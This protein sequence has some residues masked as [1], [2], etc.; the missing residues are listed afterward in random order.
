MATI[1]QCDAAREMGERLGLPTSEVHEALGSLRGEF[2]SWEDLSR[3]EA[4]CERVE[5]L[6]WD[7]ITDCAEW[8][9]PTAPK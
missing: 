6:V 4:D 1:E 5:R 9:W 7:R 8:P 3:G 2:A